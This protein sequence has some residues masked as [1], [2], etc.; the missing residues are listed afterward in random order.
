MGKRSVQ[1]SEAPAKRAKS[2]AAR[3][4][5]DVSRSA[6]ADQVRRPAARAPGGEAAAATAGAEAAAPVPTRQELLATFKPQEWAQQ[7]NMPD[8]LAADL[9]QR[10]EEATDVYDECW[11]CVGAPMSKV[12]A[13]LSC[14]S[15]IGLPLLVCH[16][17][18]CA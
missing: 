14:E 5:E 16:Y 13:V 6:A 4:P 10:F 7:Q 9:K 11:S 8:D 18:R 1:A 15:S 2:G 17:F 12:T 3:S